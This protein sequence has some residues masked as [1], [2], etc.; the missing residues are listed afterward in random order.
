VVKWREKNG[1]GFISTEDEIAYKGVTGKDR[2]YVMKDD[3]ICTSSQVGLTVGSQVRFK[4]Y[5]ATKG[6]G[7]AQVKN[8][9]GSPIVYEGKDM[10][11]NKEKSRIGRLKSS[12]KVSP[13]VSLSY[14]MDPDKKNT[15]T[16]RQK[17]SKKVVRKREVRKRE[18][19]TREARK[20]EAVS[21][22][23]RPKY[24]KDVRKRRNTGWRPLQYKP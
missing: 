4:V 8:K 23:G 5:N 9:D 6:L 18:G 2:I 17:S 15:R 7:A 20:K 14:D 24:K 12:K 22:P 21:Y 13:I 19:R 3:I 1:Y 10:D 11:P 16:D